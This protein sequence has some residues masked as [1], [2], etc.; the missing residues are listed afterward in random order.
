MNLAAKNSYRAGLDN[1]T[2]FFP[3]Q[4]EEEGIAFE[5]FFVFDGLVIADGVK[6]FDVVGGAANAS[7]AL[8]VAFEG[9]SCAVVDA[10][11]SFGEVG[12]FFD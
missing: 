11:V 8:F 3:N 12:A 10:G 9:E 5:R 2:E 6:G 7:K 4:F 1:S